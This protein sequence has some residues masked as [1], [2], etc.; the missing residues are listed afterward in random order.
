M[1]ARHPTIIV[2]DDGSQK[3]VSASGH[4][5]DD[6]KFCQLHTLQDRKS[7]LLTAV[8]QG[9]ASHLLEG[10]RKDDPTPWLPHDVPRVFPTHGI[11][12]TC[13]NY[14]FL[15]AGTVPPGL[16]FWLPL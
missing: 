5:S 2:R 12:I 15:H 8:W 3:S 1:I 7:T 13:G 4:Y 11:F 14:K 10:P 16:D 9:S 6:G